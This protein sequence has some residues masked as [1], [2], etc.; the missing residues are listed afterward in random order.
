MMMSEAVPSS[1]HTL[2]VDL[3]KEADLSYPPLVPLCD[4]IMFYGVP[5][6]ASSPKSA[7]V[8]EGESYTMVMSPS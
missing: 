6:G 7:P 3:E 5:T 4:G 2:K 8:M 1:W